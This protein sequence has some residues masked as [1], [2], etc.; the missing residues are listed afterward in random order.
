M[1]AQQI[2]FA[3]ILVWGAW[4]MATAPAQQPS[5]ASQQQAT[6]NPQQAAP[7]PQQAA[8]G[9][10]YFFTAKDQAFEAYYDNTR[11]VLDEDGNKLVAVRM[12]KFSTGFRDWI[13]TNFP[14]GESADYAVDTYSIDCQARTVGEHRLIWYDTGATELTDF[15]FGGAMSTPAR[16]S[17]KDNLMRKVCGLEE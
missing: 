15:D 10:H 1:K 8:P 17:L 9:F 16:Y 2:T 13:R 7:S 12:T 4:S 14:G 3:A 5:P 6:P 11:V